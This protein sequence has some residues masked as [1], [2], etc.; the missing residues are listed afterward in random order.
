MAGAKKKVVVKRATAAP[1]KVTVEL[2]VAFSLASAP[3]VVRW[4][5]GNPVKSA[6]VAV[7]GTSISETTD[8]KGR[9]RLAIVA[10]ATGRVI[11][12]DPAPPQLSSGPAGP[13]HGAGGASAPQFQF[14][15]FKVA[16][17]TDANGF[18]PGTATISL[19]A[20][21]GAPPHALLLSVTKDKLFIDWKA[22]F[23]KS[24]NANKAAGKKNDFLVLH[25][26][27]GPDIRQSINTFFNPGG[28]K[29]CIHY[30]VDVDGH[31][32]KLAHEDDAVV[33]TGPAFWQGRT[34]INGNSVG[35]EHVNADPDPFTG[36][37]YT[38][39]L[40]L[41]QEIRSAHTG[42]VRQRVVGHMDIG[43]TSKTNRSLGS[44]RID[45]PGNLFEWDRFE[46]AN[47]VRRRGVFVPTA[48]VFGFAPGEFVTF[49][50]SGMSRNPSTLVPDF[51]GIQRA[52]S[53]IG[54][55]V[56]PNGVT[57]SGVFDLA[58]EGAV[59]AFQ[60]RYF[61]GG[62]SAKA[63]KGFVLGAIDFETAFAIS[64]VQQDTLP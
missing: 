56:A 41:V 20:V 46:N 34:D 24:G 48:R 58:L 64:A 61:S 49:P 13:G 19:T 39:S 31:V 14:R 44:R 43:C 63:R 18:V 60:R 30:L 62:N 32:V 37:Q 38:T 17:D 21:T 28:D 23:I 47:L 12:V 45:D 53:A 16:V 36:A 57:V 7:Q 15:P 1:P 5:E 25:R 4:K 27:G 55:S 59:N 40:R 50:D 9:A 52:L 29:V 51:A 22:D 35:I 6:T 11:T 42:I 33:H 3:G 8:I 2:S 10:A 26:T 54:Y